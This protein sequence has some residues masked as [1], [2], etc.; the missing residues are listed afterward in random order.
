VPQAFVLPVQAF[1]FVRSTEHTSMTFRMVGVAEKQRLRMTLALVALEVLCRM[2]FL[3]TWRVCVG[4]MVLFLELVAVGVVVA[5]V[6]V[7][8]DV[9][10]VA[11]LVGLLQQPQLGLA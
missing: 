9:A 1:A 8:V 3:P 7:V 10:A 6:V 2:A 5:V 4:P 11:C